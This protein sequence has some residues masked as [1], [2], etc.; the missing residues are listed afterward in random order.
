MV[1]EQYA[2]IST[3]SDAMRLLFRLE[4]T[5]IKSPL[6]LTVKF[7]DNGYPN[8]IEATNNLVGVYWGTSSTGSDGG[9]ELIANPDGT[10]DV[11][12]NWFIRVATTTSGM[13]Y[14]NYI[15]Y[16]G[17]QTLAGEDGPIIYVK[18]GQ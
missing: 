16:T 11:E 13:A 4:E 3:I 6:K 12:V 15:G 5:K 14:Y 2:G 7:T 18:G 9:T 17:S 8:G 1:K 10:Y